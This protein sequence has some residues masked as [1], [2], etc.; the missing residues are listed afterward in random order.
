MITLK[1]FMETIQYKITEG[2]EYCWDCYGPNAYS[3]DS[4]NGESDEGGHTITTVFDKQD[5]TVYQMEAWDY[6]NHRCYRWINPNYIDEYKEECERRDID[7]KNAYDNVDFID[8]ETEEDILEKSRAI[9][10]GKVYDDR[11]D[12]PLRMDDDKLFELMTLAHEQDITLN[13][14]VENI[15]RD[16]IA[17]H[18]TGTSNPID[19]PVS[20]P[21]KITGKKKGKH[22]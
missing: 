15:L 9:A 7:F 17:T 18:Q 16:V 6:T 13:Q 21:A 12:V 14:L 22:D 8:L 20:K 3:L 4:W 5:Q 11:V 10:A 2:S 19:F 1:D